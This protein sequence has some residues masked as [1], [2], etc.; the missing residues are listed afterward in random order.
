MQKIVPSLWFDDQAEEAAKFYTSIFKDSKILAT[1][2]YSEVGQEITN[3]EPGSVM[4]VEFEITGQKFVALNGGPL[5]KFTEAISFIIYCDTQDEIDDYSDKLSAVPESEQCGW[6]KDKFGMSWQIVPPS[7][8]EMVRDSNP[9]KAQ[10]VMG[11]MLKMK[12][13]DIAALQAAYDNA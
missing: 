11:A 6:V 12:R 8:D 9:T 10:A 1:S 13:I 5:F 4:T 3:K 7:L 2:H